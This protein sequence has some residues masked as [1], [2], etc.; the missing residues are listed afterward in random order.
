M[1]EFNGGMKNDSEAGNQRLTGPRASCLLGCIG[2]RANHRSFSH[3]TKSG[4]QISACDCAACSAFRS[5]LNRH[6][7]SQRCEMP[8]APR[9]ATTHGPWIEPAKLKRAMSRPDNSRTFTQAANLTLT[10]AR[11]S[12]RMELKH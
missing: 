2:S 6:A 3:T 5:G 9:G 7:E 10:A 11:W 1:L 8:S 4:K 12:G